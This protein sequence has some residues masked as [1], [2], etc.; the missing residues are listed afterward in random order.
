MNELNENIPISMFNVEFQRMNQEQIKGCETYGN[1][2]RESCNDYI[3]AENEKE[4]VQL[5]L[6]DI[7]EELQVGWCAEGNT[8]GVER[9]IERA[10]DSITLYEDG[11]P[12]EKFYNFTAVEEK[13]IQVLGLY[14]H[15]NGDELIHYALKDN[16]SDVKTDCLTNGKSTWTDGKNAERIKTLTAVEN[17]DHAR[18]GKLME[19]HSCNYYSQSA[20]EAVKSM[21]Q[22]SHQAVKP[23]KK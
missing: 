16:Q 8:L 12:V 15:Y 5:A 1:D 14:R 7:Q 4:A 20:L 19:Q 10:D 3:I 6:D 9:D 21:Q 2:E 22:L 11:E 18:M 17:I 23:M 13:Q